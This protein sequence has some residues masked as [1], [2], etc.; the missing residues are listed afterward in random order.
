[1]KEVITQVVNE[2]LVSIFEVPDILEGTIEIENTETDYTAGINKVLND[3]EL[4]GLK[5]A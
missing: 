5:Q 2:Y 1:M 3:P 4:F